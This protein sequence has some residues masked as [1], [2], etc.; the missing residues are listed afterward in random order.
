MDTGTVRMVA[1]DKKVTEKASDIKMFS[2]T[3]I[4]NTLKDLT[5]NRKKASRMILTWIRSLSIIFKW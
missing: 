5:N 2:L 1:V 4:N 3:I